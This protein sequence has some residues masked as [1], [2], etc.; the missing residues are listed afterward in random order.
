[1][2]GCGQSGKNQADEELDGRA[3]RGKIGGT[4]LAGRSGVARGANVGGKFSEWRASE[5]LCTLVLAIW[6]ATA[7][8][9]PVSTVPA[10]TAEAADADADSDALADLKPDG[11]GLPLTC[12]P[13]APTLTIPPEPEKATVLPGESTACAALGV[14]ACREGCHGACS[15]GGGVP[16]YICFDAAGHEV[17][18]GK[19][20]G[21]CPNEGPCSA[22][23]LQPWLAAYPKCSRPV[24]SS[25]IPL[26][27]LQAVLKPEALPPTVCSNAAGTKFSFIASCALH[28]YTLVDE[29]HCG[30]FGG[31]SWTLRISPPTDAT[32]NTP[33]YPFLACDATQFWFEKHYGFSV[34]TEPDALVVT[35][36]YDCGG[37]SWDPVNAK[38][39]E[40]LDEAKSAFTTCGAVYDL[41]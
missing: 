33:K 5:C 39:A 38:W 1:M 20:G 21:H 9:S 30:N 23:Q 35:G 10:Q 16:A 36:G 41:P 34:K 19:D 32:L 13:D 7:C 4:G 28:E 12:P 14:V 11:A 25:A 31:G 27:V 17:G 22:A 6:L 40:W 15:P 3:G 24:Y 37:C 8:S 2:D 18:F 26:S 29:D